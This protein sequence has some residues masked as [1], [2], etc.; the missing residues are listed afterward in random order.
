MTQLY[1]NR[2]P[3]DDVLGLVDLYRKE[4]LGWN[5]KLAHAW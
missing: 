3:V 2:D 5:V 4:H 1:Q